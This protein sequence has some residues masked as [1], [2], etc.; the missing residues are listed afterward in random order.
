MNHPFQP[1]VDNEAMR[2]FGHRAHIMKDQLYWLPQGH[3]FT[4][5]CVSVTISQRF[6]VMI[7]MSI[8][9]DAFGLQCEDFDGRVKAVVIAPGS[10][11][12]VHAPDTRLI[13]FHINP[14][15]PEFAVFR[16]LV[17]KGP[18]ELEPSSYA[19][20]VNDM[21]AAYHG[22]LDAEAATILHNEVATITS[23]L[24]PVQKPLDPRIET[25]LRIVDE[26]NGQISLEDLSDRVGLSYHWMSRLFADAVGLPLRTYCLWRKVQGA[27]QVLLQMPALVEQVRRTGHLGGTGAQGVSL[28]TLAHEAGFSDSAHLAHTMGELCG[29]PLSHFLFSG[30]VRLHLPEVAG[31]TGGT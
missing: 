11:R 1:P 4:T 8:S 29:G 12:H 17:R 13:S 20:L 31:N 3:V 2:P 26:E 22:Q 5:P 6:Y 16:A 19:H 25:V 21:E 24:M 30:D 28:T 27:S 15:H 10:P 18:L 9:G 7:T 14:R 23:A